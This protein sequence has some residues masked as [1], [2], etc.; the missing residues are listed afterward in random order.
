MNTAVTV[1][2]LFC[3]TEEGCKVCAPTKNWPSWFLVG[4]STP[5]YQLTN[6]RDGRHPFGGDLNSHGYC[7]G[8]YFVENGRCHKYQ[9]EVRLYWKACDKFE[10]NPW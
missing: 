9:G 3:Q 2:C 6:V 8:C 7:E 1:G 10:E 4:E 5:T